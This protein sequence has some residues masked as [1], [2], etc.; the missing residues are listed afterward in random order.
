MNLTIRR[1][2][3]ADAAAYVR[4]MGDP[5]VYAGTMQMPYAS[6][7]DWAT[8][9]AALVGKP[10]LALVAE[11]DGEVVGTAGLHPAGMSM[12]RRHA[13]F[14][15]ISVASSAQRR[16]IGDALMKA[17]CDYADRWVGALRLELTVFTDNA[18]AIRLYRRHGFEIE[19]TFR[20]YVLRDGEYVDA[21]SMAR[22]RSAPPGRPPSPP[23]A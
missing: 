20:D 8:R 18:T 4:V 3:L 21:H 14:I 22:L 12:R 5:A 13:W 1:T 11:L 17:M 15:G 7:E 23:A 6:E 19:G 16:G 2:R 10:D 9:L